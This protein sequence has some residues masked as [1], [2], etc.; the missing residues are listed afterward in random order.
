MNRIETNSLIIDLEPALGGKIAQITSRSSGRQWLARHPRL[1]WRQLTNDELSLP[2]AY[3]RFGDLGGWD[4]CCP[5]VGYS[6][7][8]LK[9]NQ[10]VTDHGE[11]WV[12]APITSITPQGFDCRWVGKLVPFE[13]KRRLQVDQAQPRIQIDYDLRASIDQPVPIIWSNHPLFAIEPGM[14]LEFAAGTEMLIAS[15][16]S[17]LGSAGTKF[18]WPL[19]GSIDASIV[20]PQSG[21]ATKLFSEVI[22]PGSI[23][24]IASNG[25]QFKMSWSSQDISLPIRVGLWMNY[26]GWAGDGG[27]PLNNL[28]I[29]PSLGMPDR[30]DEAAVRGTA[31]VL[32]PSQAYKWRL[33]I[34]IN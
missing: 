6:T 26:G 1:T 30:L 7:N 33:M 28:G 29:E 15:D 25:E 31:F 18:L 22:N 3:T 14:R 10:D 16:R 24:L 17:S 27:A 13:F 19:A 21:S 20:R 11:C 5:T 9:S 8:P 2:D 4:E 34:D 32:Q 12:K 23:A